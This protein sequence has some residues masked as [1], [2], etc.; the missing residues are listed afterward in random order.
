MMSI[1]SK[2]NLTIAISSFLTSLLV[3]HF[4]CLNLDWTFLI[5]QM[6]MRSLHRFSIPL[7]MGAQAL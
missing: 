1:Q 5:I 4:F 6:V 3:T 2:L 7:K